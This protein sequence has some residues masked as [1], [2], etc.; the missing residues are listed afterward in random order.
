MVRIV[1]FLSFVVL[2]VCGG[3]WAGAQWV[4]QTV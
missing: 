1:A 4:T 2:I 3:Q